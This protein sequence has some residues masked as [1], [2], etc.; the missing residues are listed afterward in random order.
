MPAEFLAN[1]ESE[2][3]RLGHRHMYGFV[4]SDNMPARWLYQ[5]RGY[6]VVHRCRT[7]T[8]LKRL[9]LVDGT[10]WLSGRK[11]MRPLSRATPAGG[12]R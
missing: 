5:T 3:A 9:M 7:R 1:V 6:E 12:R 8:V 4:D 10:A 11:G 2:L